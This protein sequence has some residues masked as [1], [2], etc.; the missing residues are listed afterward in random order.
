M[1]NFCPKCGNE[2]IA[3]NKHGY[4]SKFCS[5]SCANAR[6]KTESSNKK[7]S[8]SLKGTGALT[9]I[10]FCSCEICHIPFLWDS[11]HKGSKRCCQNH[12]C[13]R[14]FK[15]NVR[16]GRVGG[17]KPNS[18]RVTRSVYNGQQM[19]SGAE[20]SFAKLCDSHNIQWHKNSTIFFEYAPGKKY[21]PDFYLSEYNAWVEIKGKRYYRDDDP[22]RWAS[23]PNHYV[24]W[25]DN[26]TLPEIVLARMKGN[27]PS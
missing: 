17:Y 26:I 9:K 5:R 2:F 10:I 27:D 4:I 12:H 16:K 23:V 6:T 3:S 24:I 1:K 18:T 20:L 7:T 19:D 14:Q 11:F 22:L 15:Y 13:N 8:D 25:S 21:Y